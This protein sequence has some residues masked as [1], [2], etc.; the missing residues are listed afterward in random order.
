[1]ERKISVQSGW[2][3]TITNDMDDF[4]WDNVNWYFYIEE[5]KKLIIGD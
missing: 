3:V 2:T 4:R 1:M 5:A